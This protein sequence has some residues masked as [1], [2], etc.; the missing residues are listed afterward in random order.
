MSS[1]EITLPKFLV[2]KAA[3]PCRVV[4]TPLQELFLR[5]KLVLAFAALLSFSLVARADD[6]T[7]NALYG[8]AFQ[9]APDYG[10][11]EDLGPVTGVLA[12]DFT[13]ATYTI[14]VGGF[15]YGGSTVTADG[16]YSY[17]D[18]FTYVSIAPYLN[19]P[20]TI[21][22]GSFTV[23]N[24]LPYYYVDGIAVT[25]LLDGSSGTIGATIT[26][27]PSSI[28]LLGTGMLGIVGVVRKRFAL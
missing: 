25:R 2:A 5:F 13:T 9:S 11:Y 19:S 22:G 16:I 18:E 21:A 26:P 10:Y 14:E 15:S 24:R 28:A 6:I 12:V 3:T 8:E 17:D 27:E 20:D 7:Q 1:T 23:F 4:R